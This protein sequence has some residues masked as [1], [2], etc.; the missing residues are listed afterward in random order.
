MNIIAILDGDGKGSMD[1]YVVHAFVGDECRGTGRV[2]SGRYFIT[3]YGD[4][5]ESV[6]FL[7]RNNR[8]G[9]VCYAGVTLTFHENVI[10]S[11]K[12]P[13]LLTLTPTGISNVIA[14]PKGYK[15]YSIEGIL[16]G[17]DVSAESLKQ[18]PK[19]VYI[20]NGKKMVIEK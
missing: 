1:D 7:L 2:I 19:G 20:I 18:L 14:S 8:T 13:Y 9:E 4:A 11:M 3:I 15:V 16:I 17:D 10:G 12:K 6:K 5:P